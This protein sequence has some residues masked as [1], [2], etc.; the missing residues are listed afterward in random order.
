M[1]KIFVL[2]GEPSGDKLASTIISKLKIEN[3]E[4]EYLSVGGSNLK[5][6]GIESIF[7]LKDITYLGFTSVLLNIFKIRNK[8]NTTVDEILR[9]NPDILF[10]VDSPDF[11]LRVAEKV[12]KINNNIKTIHYV[13]PQVWVW[14]KNRVKRIK[15]F[16]DHMLLLFNFEKKYFDQ[17]NIKNT[18]VGHPLIE[19]KDNAKITLD[20]LI[21]KD[22]KIISLFPGSRKSE[23][24]VLLPIL[25]DFIKLM[26][27]KNFNYSFVFHA[28]DENRE[29]II[30]KIKNTILD[31]IDVVSDENMKD[32]VLSN[33]I[34]AVSKSGTI[35]LQI[36][37]ANIPSI[38]IYKLSFINFMIFKLLVN[39]K[40]ANIINIINNKEVIPELL[41]K[42]CNAEEIYKTVTYFL[43]NPELIEKQL[44]DCRK[45]LEG[46]KSKSSSSSEAASILSNYLVS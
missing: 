7:D 36:S 1:K 5:K 19:K 10:S 12:K 31:N 45:T 4:I 27:K 28:T 38:I 32:Q 42:E 18:F 2:T 23:T 33:S 39:V 41:Q 13:A 40:F 43:K 21:S 26:N 20:N 17:E 9:F 46:I 14:R 8:I 29:F 11:T 6:I 44:I 30:N 35:S 15:K 34:F 24:N 37:S 16:I 25:L 22:K 3:S